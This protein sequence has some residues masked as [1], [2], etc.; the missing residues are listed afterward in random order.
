MTRAVEAAFGVCGFLPLPSN[1]QAG[2][3][4][5]QA[6]QHQRGTIEVKATQQASPFSWGEN[7]SALLASAPGGGS[8]VVV[9]SKLKF[10]FFDY[11]RNQANVEKLFDAIDGR[12]G[13]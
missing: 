4:Q 7:I 1:R 5:Q 10:G 12:L 9:Q 3:T 2:A 11:G 8:Q 6:G 13:P